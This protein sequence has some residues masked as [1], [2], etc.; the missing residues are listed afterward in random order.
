MSTLKPL[1]CFALYVFES[2]VTNHRADVDR[3]MIYSVRLH[4]PD[5]KT[6]NT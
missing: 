6:Y 4:Q 2:C 1:L 3:V 5:D